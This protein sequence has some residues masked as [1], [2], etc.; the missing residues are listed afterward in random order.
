MPQDGRPNNSFY[1]VAAIEGE[2]LFSYF[3]ILIFF[4]LLV[5]FWETISFDGERFSYFILT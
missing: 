1:V 4:G 3:K 2:G 5:L